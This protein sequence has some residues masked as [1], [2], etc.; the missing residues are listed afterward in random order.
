MHIRK[1]SE[2]YLQKKDRFIYRRQF[3]ATQWELVLNCVSGK[4]S[5]RCNDFF[6]NIS[7]VARVCAAFR[8]R[9][10]GGIGKCQG[11]VRS[12]TK[13]APCAKPRCPHSTATTST[14]SEGT[15]P[16]REGACRKKHISSER[17]GVWAASRERSYEGIATNANEQ[18]SR[19]SKVLLFTQICK[20]YQD[21]LI[22]LQ[23]NSLSTLHFT[24]YTSSS[25]A[26]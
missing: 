4:I 9:S 16:L 20:H 1:Q 10:F 25:A 18:Q 5:Q 6:A 15:H 19:C 17:A 22:F 12:T 26:H 13:N 2:K 7:S 11:G 14:F 24:P 3:S 8:E 21:F 23:M